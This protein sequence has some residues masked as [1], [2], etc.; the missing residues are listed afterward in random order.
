MV[1]RTGFCVRYWMFSHVP[2]LAHA[3]MGINSSVREQNSASSQSPGR[4]FESLATHNI[5]AGP[6]IKSK[7]KRT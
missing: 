2:P 3:A 7:S 6:R 5:S 1:A 4:G